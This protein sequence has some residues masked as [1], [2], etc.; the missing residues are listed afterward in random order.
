MK[1]CPF[2]G[3]SGATV[4]DITSDE[5]L[6]EW[7]VACV[8]EKCGAMMLGHSQKEAVDRWEKRFISVFDNNL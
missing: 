8:S 3:A 7:R 1:N 6:E 4:C 2:C 5:G